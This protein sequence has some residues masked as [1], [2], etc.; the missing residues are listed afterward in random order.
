MKKSYKMIVAILLSIFTFTSIT[1]LGTIAIV[2]SNVEFFNFQP[3]FFGQ[4]IVYVH[5][6][7]SVFKAKVTWTGVLIF[8]LLGG[9]IQLPINKFSKSDN[10]AY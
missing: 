9:V 1:F 7:D 10:H 4:D 6:Q 2:L 8:G 5:I 3:K